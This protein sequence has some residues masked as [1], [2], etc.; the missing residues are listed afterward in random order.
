MLNFLG[1]KRS[2]QHHKERKQRMI[3]DNYNFLLEKLDE[4]IRKYYKN[5]LI[6]GSIYSISIL[7]ISFISFTAM[8]YFGHFGNTFRTILFYSFLL[9]AITVLIK[10]IIIPISKLYKLGSN[11]SHEQAAEII[12]KHFTTV[13]DKL[14]NVLQLKHLTKDSSQSTALIEAGINQK[15]I[16]LKPIPFTN[17]IDFNSNKKFLK[18]LIV[19]FVIFIA[20]GIVNPSVFTDGTQRLVAHSSD[21]TPM[22]PFEFEILNADLK[23]IKNEDFQLLIKIKGEVLPERAYIQLGDNSF[24]LNKIDK[25]NFRYTL[26]NIQEDIDFKLSADGFDSRNYTISAQPKPLLVNFEVAID[27]PAY[28][29]MKNEVIQDIGDLTIPQGSLLKWR[30]YTTSSENLFFAFRDSIFPVQQNNLDEYVVQAKAM[31][32]NGYQIATS[33]QFV[34][35]TDTLNYSLTVIPDVYPMISVEQKADSSVLKR[36]FFKGEIKDDYGF[37]RLTFNYKV[38]DS[39]KRVTTQIPINKSTTQNQ[40]FYV[41]DF[42]NL[43][44]K[45]GDEI[46]YYFEVFDN[47]GVNG[48]KSSRTQKM[49]FKVP[50]KEELEKKSDERSKEIVNDLEKSLAD[51]KKLKKDIDELNKSLIDKEKLGWQEKKQLEEIIEAQKKLREKIEKSKNENKKNNLEQKEFNE[52]D[53]D[54]LEKQEKL[55][56]L[57]EQLMTPEMKEL[58]EELEKMM[59]ELNKDKL[60]D[61]LDKIELSNEELEKELDRSL[62]IFKQLEFEQKLNETIEKLDELQKKQEELAKKSEDKNENAGELQKEQEELN[63]KFDELKDKMDELEKKNEAL[64]NPNEIP[65]MKEEEEAVKKEMEESA[66]QLG[67]KNKKKAAESQQNAADEMQKMKDKLGGLQME[68]QSAGSAEDMEDIRALLENL[69]Q[70][71]FD[72]EALIDD[73]KKANR[74]DPKFVDYSQAQKKLIDDSKT[75]EDSLFALSKRVMQLEATVNKEVTAIKSNMKKALGYLADRNSSYAASNQQFAMTSINNLA[76]ILDEALQNMQKQMQ[77]GQGSCSKP[78]GKNPKPSAAQ[79]KKMQEQMKEQMQ[80]MKEAMENGKNPGDKPGSK[81]GDKPGQGQGGMSKELAQMAAKQAA[82]RRELQKMSEELEKNGEKGAGGNLKKLSDLMEQN[83]TDI[84]NKNITRQTMMRQEEILTRLLES[85]KA[86]RERE[87]DNKRESKEGIE[88]LQR[89]PNDFFEYNKQKEK[90]V[91][92]LKTLP[93]NYLPFYK[94]KTNLYF[95]NIK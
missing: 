72:Q 87:K 54:I 40:Y 27:Y 91:E 71:S 68:M 69:I 44:L 21:F 64:E 5:Q 48:S 49:Q 45:A 74:T 66:D 25:S 51:A 59:E 47:D 75:I 77:S 93:P 41:W 34:D 8:E 88:N 81:P 13:S 61:Q 58:Y 62:E 55:E 84:V 6:K 76:L 90:E 17:A 12:G 20:V 16:A 86:E 1:S 83:E 30:F 10:F 4:F 78:G 28:T 53:Q 9:L 14:Y 94:N 26:K 46:D 79:M 85:E 38:G 7:T 56:E 11:I 37:N 95:E 60:K 43:P 82:I 67:Q 24:L 32:S 35:N 89:N 57:F 52:L 29:G 65:E 2:N 73:V 80:K 39:S 36:I 23:G 50:T 19:P 42:E 70:L 31:Y 18:Y 33:N 92:L 15:I 63:K 22:A 3:Q